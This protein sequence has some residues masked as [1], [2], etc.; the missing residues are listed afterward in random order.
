ML[1]NRSNNFSKKLPIVILT[2]IFVSIIIYLYFY[3][4]ICWTQ[5]ILNLTSFNYKISKW[6]YI[7]G[8]IIQVVVDGVSSMIRSNNAC[9][10]PR[11]AFFYP[12]YFFI[13]TLLSRRYLIQFI[14]WGLD[15]TTYLLSLFLLIKLHP[16][17]SNQLFLLLQTLNTSSKFVVRTWNILIH[18]LW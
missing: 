11:I 10:S 4:E 17:E 15:F 6:P 12:L 1:S 2:F 8:C 13:Q 5:L 9:V 14:V 16:L 18:H 7:M 3:V